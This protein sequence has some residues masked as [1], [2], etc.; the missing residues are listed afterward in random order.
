MANAKTGTPKST[1]KVA[2]LEDAVAVPSVVSAKKGASTTLTKVLACGKFELRDAAGAVGHPFFQSGS[3]ETS[4]KVRECYAKNL[5]KVAEEGQKKKFMDAFHEQCAT[6]S[7]FSVAFLSPFQLV[8]KENNAGAAVGQGEAGHG[9]DKQDSLFRVFVQ[10]PQLQKELVNWVLELLPT[11]S[12]LSRLALNNLRWL[13]NIHDSEG[14]TRKLMECLQACEAPLQREI[15]HAIPEVIDDLGHKLTVEGLQ[16]L[17]VEVPSFTGIIVDTYSSLNMEA[18]IV[19]GIRDDLLKRLDSVSTEFLPSALKFLL[20][21]T[22]AKSLPAVVSG[23]RTSVDL[24][25]DALN[26]AGAQQQRGQSLQNKQARAMN[27]HRLTLEALRTAMSFDEHMC[28]AFL[29]SISAARDHKPLDV[30]ILLI[31]HGLTKMRSKVEMIVR[32]KVLSHDLSTGLMRR[33]LQK[34]GYILVEQFPA[35]LAI[36]DRAVRA[37]EPTYVDFGAFLY[38]CSFDVFPD[39]FNRQNLISNILSHV[40]STTSESECSAG[41]NVLIKLA[42]QPEQLKELWQFVETVLDHLANLS[43]SNVRKA[44]AVFTA[45]I[46]KGEVGGVLDDKVYGALCMVLRKQMTNMRDVYKRS[47]VVGAAAMLGQLCSISLAPGKEGNVAALSKKSAS[48][49]MIPRANDEAAKEFDM[50]LNALF[51]L[52]EPL[53]L[54]LAFDELSLVLQQFQAENFKMPLVEKIMAKAQFQM[55]VF[56]T[57]CGPKSDIVEGAEVAHSLNVDDVTMAINFWGLSLPKTRDQLVCVCPCLSLLQACGRKLTGGN[58]D[59]ICGLIGAPVLLHPPNY[60]DTFEDLSEAEQTRVTLSVFHCIN[61]MREVLN[62]FYD[63][64]D[65]VLRSRIL[66]RLTQIHDLEEVLEKCLRIRPMTLPSVRDPTAVLCAASM[67]V[68]AAEPSNKKAKS[69]AGAKKKKKA[70]DE[71]TDAAL[72]DTG[73][74]LPRVRAIASQFR[75]FILPVFGMFN[76]AAMNSEEAL[77]CWLRP[78]ALHALLQSLDEYCQVLFETSQKR[79]NPFGRKAKT[80]GLEL[81]PFSDTKKALSKVIAVIVPAL[82]ENL[83]RVGAF[84]AQWSATEGSQWAPTGQ[85]APPYDHDAAASASEERARHEFWWY[86]MPSQRMV[87][88]IFMRIFVWLNAMSK[89]ATEEDAKAYDVQMRAILT[90][91][92]GRKNSSLESARNSGGALADV[93]KEAWTYLSSLNGEIESLQTAV[94]FTGMLEALALYGVGRK[95]AVPSHASTPAGSQVASD[96][97]VASSEK[98]YLNELSKYCL[99]FLRRAWTSSSGGIKAAD[100]RTL[101]D[102]AIMHS[103]HTSKALRPII[104]ALQIATDASVDEE[105]GEAAGGEAALNADFGTLSKTT[106]SVFYKTTFLALGKLLKE[107]ALEKNIIGLFEVKMAKLVACERLNRAVKLLIEMVKGAKCTTQVKA[108]AL[109][110]GK[111]YLELVQRA[112][113]FFGHM[114]ATESKKTIE[115]LKQIEDGSRVLQRLCNQAKEEGA[116]TLLPLIP[117][118]KK[119][120]EKL[121]IETCR[122]VDSAGLSGAL[123]FGPLKHKNLRGDVMSSQVSYRGVNADDDDDDDDDDDENNNEEEAGE[124]GEGAQLNQSDNEEQPKKRSKEAKPSA[125]G[126][127][128]AEEGG[129]EEEIDEEQEE[130]AGEEEE[131]EAANDEEEDVVVS[132]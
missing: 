41:L 118:A 74:D 11:Q 21:T 99:G 125:K 20:Q 52:P 84:I 67:A 56:A 128:E 105:R 64:Q 116:V 100:V 60:V 22:P 91:I 132:D 9:L 16:N 32:K 3:M 131:V 85:E 124:E 73:A 90:Q 17:M 104:M 76:F 46:W 78:F 53:Y 71:A 77:F 12:T 14:F 80:G 109:R 120:V 7:R 111:L 8:T 86:I 45:L 48:H 43:K 6:D 98:A 1:K 19:A 55:E 33:A 95:F 129:P 114:A 66:Q 113:P 117:A 101:V 49:Q 63:Q 106:V 61:W 2:R 75:S 126:K 92:C 42:R 37:T 4:A 127:E 24:S 38:T 88:D 59:V 79:A 47:G 107:M 10:S 39:I 62:T 108:S 94:S 122:I 82:S 119:S 15:I 27:Y 115:C 81:G 65:M 51:A 96:V 58:L 69:T 130:L 103:T 112:M 70:D 35:I 110:E 26:E 40:G 123:R 34:N 25:H 87:F 29:A 121:V 13:N 57:A 44:W 97:L 36:A 31:A 5:P 54:A 89:S 50:H 30:W 72:L 102:K 28:A 83:A 23:I 18:S 68:G 93:K